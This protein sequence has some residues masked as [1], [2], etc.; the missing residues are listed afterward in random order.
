[1]ELQ[2]EGR[3]LEIR[4]AW[5]E[6]I[7]EE[8]GRLDRHHPGLV[9]HLRVSIEET[10]GH[11]AGGHEVRVVASVPNDTVV[12]KRKGETVRPLLVEAFDTLGLQLKELQRKRRQ[13]T[14]EP[15]AGVV[16][17]A[18][19][20]IKSLFPYESYGFLM[21]LDGQEVYF[22]ENALKDVSMAQLAEGDEVRFGE[23]EGD[24]G[25]T[26]AWVKLVK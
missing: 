19:G 9:H 16:G 20:T 15:E 8:K 24:K 22:H 13:T 23:G 1:M 2:V 17:P 18:S 10:A 25:P 12:V 4:K 5:Q 14:K 7:E 21:T 6:K 26:A 11:K 3:N